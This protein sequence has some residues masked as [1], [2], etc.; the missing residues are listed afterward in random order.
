MLFLIFKE[1]VI[2]LYDVK[3]FWEGVKVIVSFRNNGEVSGFF[4]I[5]KSLV[6]FVVSGV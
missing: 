2:V 5:V 1:S 6:D 3:L 4:V